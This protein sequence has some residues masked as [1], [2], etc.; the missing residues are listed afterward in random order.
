MKN[1]NYIL[2]LDLGTNSIGWSAV[3]LDQQ[4][5]DLGVRVFPAGLDCFNTP[6][7]ASL[8]EER[9]TKR[10]ARRTHKRRA[11]RKA[12]LKKCLRELNWMPEDGKAL[13]D[14]NKLNAYELRSRAIQGKVSLYEL[15]RILLHLNQRRGFLSLRKSQEASDK[16]NRG[17]LGEI[18]ALQKAIETS[19]KETLGNF[20]HHL[21]LEGKENIRIRKR[22]I[23]REMLYH[24][25]DLIWKKQQAFYPKI[26]SDSLRWGSAGKKEKPCKVVKPVEH[27]K[28]ETLLEQFGLENLT[29]FQRAVYWKEKSIG[30][31]E[32]EG[33]LAQERI[34]N[35][36]LDEEATKAL[37][38]KARRAPVADRR[39]Q[40]FRML[41]EVNNLRIYDASEPGKPIDRALSEEERNVVLESLSTKDKEKFEALKKKIAKIPDS[42]EVS[43]IT[44]NLESGGRT[45]ING[46]RTDKELRAK[47]YY[48]AA[49]M[50]LSEKE[51]N[52][53]VEALSEPC[54]T[55]DDIYDSLIEE[56][57][58][59]P[60]IAERIQHVSLPSGYGHLSIQALEKILPYLR[61]GM[62]YMGKDAENSAIHSAG[63]QRRDE[64]IN[65]VFDFLPLL[66]SDALPHVPK[67][68]NPVVKRALSEL[69][70]VVNG[71]IRKYGKPARIHLEMARELKMGEKKRKEHQ[72]QT[73]AWEKERQDAA[74]ELCE[75]GVEPNSNAILLYRLW[76]EQRE[77]C[78][79]SGRTISK[80]NLISGEVDIDHILPG[81]SLDD[82]RMNKVVCF[83]NENADK[84]NRTPYQWLA[85]RDPDRY[86][87]VLQR[88][89]KLPLPK[90]RRFS[91]E[92]VPE[93]W[94]A[95]DLNDTAWIA[96]AALQYLACLLDSP[97][98]LLSMKGAH[99]AKL[100]EQW[101]LHGL[102]RND[103]LDLKNRDDH[104]HHALD[105]AVIACCDHKTLQ[106]LARD[107]RRRTYWTPIEDGTRCF[108]D[109]YDAKF[110]S[111]PWESFRDD[112][113]A[114]LNQIIV[115]HKP[116]RK[117]SGKL[118][119][120][121][122]YG[123]TETEGVIVHR[124]PVESLS[125]KEVEHIRDPKI[126]QIIQA[127]LDSGGTLKDDIFMPNGRPIKK[128]RMLVKAS[129]AVPRRKNNPGELV[130]PRNIHHVTI[131]TNGSETKVYPINVW[132]AIERTKAKQALFQTP[133]NQAESNTLHLCTKDTIRAEIDGKIEY[134]VF[135]T[136]ATTTMQMKFA[137]LNDA[138]KGNKHPETGKSLLRTCM[139]VTF[140]KK[141]PNARKVDVIPTGEVRNA[142]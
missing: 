82:S 32:F 58:L 138:S 101:Q 77:T 137:Y 88:A 17:M 59:S 62:D 76:R 34:K 86:G 103:G 93:G 87:A 5:V 26:L 55:D 2:G 107:H 41:Q 123:P 46:M 116:C 63:Y 52:K 78:V 25:F 10:A 126:S 98:Q 29:F 39:F 6:K 16:D 30:L 132:D 95:R 35:E 20:L 40:E 102:L 33:P 91:M 96:K 92:D 79:Y 54:A 135:K 112:L 89:A 74:A 99:T 60:E 51:K 134:F 127:H 19:G 110:I 13:D 11:K 131:Y 111:P 113:K 66:N 120:E 140:T 53:I 47:K 97:T 71:L 37:M 118:H 65:K 28:G 81:R 42:P 48:G 18:S 142:Q 124:K 106:E 108:H 49:W 15:G 4:K 128:V 136:M 23:R 104:R 119:L 90:R 141:F 14:W 125:E 61:T 114:S 8:N 68:N 36:K 70:K 56:C 43:Q 12:Y 94:L 83:R 130:L 85:E 100:R 67:I 31:C 21:Y 80:E 117:V 7:E 73:R 57:K 121:T 64:E 72:Q 22:H 1:S 27:K 50:E 84:G 122:N 129:D 3:F 109:R 133:P 69:R 45:H 38:K 24:E 44:F 115:S 139:P 75:W 105:A 9:R